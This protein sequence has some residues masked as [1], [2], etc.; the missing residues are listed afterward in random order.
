MAHIFQSSFIQ[1]GRRSGLFSQRAIEIPLDKEDDVDFLWHA[2][3]EEEVS[4]RLA[5]IVFALDVERASPFPR[6]MP[7]E[8]VTDLARTEQTLRSSATR[9]PSPRFRFSCLS[10][11]TRTS[12]RRRRRTS[13]SNCTT[14]SAS[15]SSSSRR[16]RRV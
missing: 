10:R 16:S 12:G 14:S 5:Q 11:A 8:R 9:T 3:I 13:G 1:L 4:K 15:R 2:W 7:A 6:D